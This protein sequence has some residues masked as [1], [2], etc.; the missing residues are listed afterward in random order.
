M[1]SQLKNNNPESNLKSTQAPSFIKGRVYSV[2][3]DDTHPFFEKVLGEFD[4]TYIGYIFWGNLNLKEGDIDQNPLKLSMAKPY[5][6]WVTY[7]PLK[8]E[9]VDLIQAPS[10]LHYVDLDGNTTNVEYFY[11]P[12]INVWNNSAGNPLPRET[13]IAKSNGEI[14]LGEY[15]NEDKISNTKNMVPFEGDMIL[16]GRFGNSIRF[17]SSNP[18][19]KN[20]WSENNSEGEPITIISNGQTPQGAGV[21]EDINGDA[22]SIYLT[23][24]QNINNFE[25]AS[26]NFKSL[27]STFEE[28]QSGL[29]PLTNFANSSTSIEELINQSPPLSVPN[30]IPDNELLVEGETLPKDP[31][32]KPEDG[33]EIHN[34]DDEGNNSGEGY[35]DLVKIPGTYEDNNKRFKELYLV[36][37]KYA[38]G[39]KLVTNSIAGPLM[40]MLK[41]AEK[42]GVIVKV[43]S[44]FRSPINDII[45]NGKKLQTG[46]KSLRIKNLKSKYKGK[47]K[48]PWLKTTTCI[49]PFEDYKVGDT[50]R[51]FNGGKYFDPRTA[52]SYTSNHGYSLAIDFLTLQSNSQAFTWL[53]FHGWKYGFIRTVDDEDWHFDYKPSLAQKGPTAKLS[54]TYQPGKSYRQTKN[55]W[56]NVF[57]PTEP[58]W[59]NEWEIFQNQQAQELNA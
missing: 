52:P 9:I 40:T 21:I 8:T 24:N 39:T 30:S 14:P 49:E 38:V 48:E 31:T 13:D 53:S 15:T 58:N 26:N 22:S 18:E 36:P 54:Y 46:Q 10:H 37:K 59:A 34:H 55:L 28:P 57:G 19:G 6:N 50:V 17:G 4:P 29:T 23:S 47:V 35:E 42:D 12:P 33:N 43:N 2:I 45:L 56:N 1:R 7:T 51:G 3:L 11:Y 16:E 44:A 20:N 25:I 27:N 5:F 41:A 32:D